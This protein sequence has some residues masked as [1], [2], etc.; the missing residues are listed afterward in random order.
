MISNNLAPFN[1][2]SMIKGNLQSKFKSYQNIFLV[3]LLAEQQDL[4]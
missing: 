1:T 3:N 4:A 2:Y